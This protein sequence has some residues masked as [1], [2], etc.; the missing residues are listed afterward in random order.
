MRPFPGKPGLSEKQNIF[1]Y[2]LSRA[3]RLIENAFG[4]LTQRWQF[5]RKDLVALPENAIIYMQ[6][7]IVLH[8][9]LRME[10]IDSQKPVYVP[11]KYVDHLGP[12]QQ[13]INGTWR[14]GADNNLQEIDGRHVASNNHPKDAAAVREA[15]ADYFLTPEGEVEWQYRHV[16]R[17]RDTP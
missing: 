16:R 1:N 14:D 10:E 6:A 17:G 11:P 2:R 7:V 5:L 9:W 3:R 12:N 8:N 13:I 15:Y 4:V